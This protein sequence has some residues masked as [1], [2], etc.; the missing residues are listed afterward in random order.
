MSAAR[1]LWVSLVLAAGAPLFSTHRP[2]PPGAAQSS[3]AWPHEFEGRPL[4]RV[5]LSREESRFLGDFPGAVARFTDGQRDILMRRVTRP[6]RKLHPA[7]DCYRGWG[8]EVGAA[9][10]HPDRDGGL[11]RCF[12]AHRAGA[13]RE[14]CEQIRDDEGRSF[15]DVSSWYWSASLERSPA[16]WLVVTVAGVKAE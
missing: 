5:P 4:T 7:E 8:F 3:R 14:V 9:R 12:T 11:W 15:I 2:A 1:C 10:I 16:P 13:A 6:T